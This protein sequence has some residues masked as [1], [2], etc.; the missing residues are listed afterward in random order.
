MNTITPTTIC[1]KCVYFL[2][3][4]PVWYD[5][6]CRN[7]T[8]RRHESI[9]P[10]TG[11]KGYLVSNDLGVVYLSDKPYPYA[12]DVNHGNCQHYKRR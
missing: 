8:V 4:G 3:R 10:V 11:E 9:D 2:R 12:R 7:M 1:A 6:F 5:M